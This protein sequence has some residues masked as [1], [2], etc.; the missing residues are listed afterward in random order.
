MI[1]I[2]ILIPTFNRAAMLCEALDLILK[3]DCEEIFEVIVSDNHSSD[4]TLEILTNRY[5]HF[6]KLKLTQ[7]PASCGPIFNWQ[8]ALSLASGTHVHWHW[9]DDYL[10]GPFY[11]EAVALMRREQ[12]NIVISSVKIVFEDGFAPTLYSQGFD[13]SDLSEKAL[14]KLLINRS[15]PV[16]PAACIL[17]LDA[18]K[19]HFYIELPSFGSY[20]PIKCA[21]GTDTLMIAGSILENS[22]VAYL[23]KALFCFR[24]HPG[25][26]TTIQSHYYRSY[27]VAFEWFIRKYALPIPLKLRRRAFGLTICNFYEKK[28]SLA[29]FTGFLLQRYKIL[30]SK[31]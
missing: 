8:H 15:L 1:K 12:V 7:P 25:S 28:F 30:L 17:P 31:L 22:R 27:F 23:E 26:L 9:S 29:A 21:M 20:D 2:S 18:V 11:Q 4:K 14:N 13:R 3:Y 6:K 24:S 5:P 16:S 10:C 19:K